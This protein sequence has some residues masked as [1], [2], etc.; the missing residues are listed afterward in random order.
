MCVHGLQGEL[1]G[2]DAGPA[3]AGVVPEVLKW[4]V[5]VLTHTLLHATLPRG[6]RGRM[7]QEKIGGKRKGVKDEEEGRGEGEEET[8]DISGAKRERGRGVWVGKVR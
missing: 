7:V 8:E 3:T 2:V 4:V 1:H 6:G 5:A